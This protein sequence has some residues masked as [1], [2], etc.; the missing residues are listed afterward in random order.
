MPENTEVEA[1]EAKK[2][3]VVLREIENVDAI[4]AIPQDQRVETY[5]TDRK[6]LRKFKL[7]ALVPKTEDECQARYKCKLA[8]LIGKG[9]VQ[10]MYSISA[11][12]IKATLEGSTDEAVISNQ[13]QA[14]ADEKSAETTRK[15]GVATVVKQKASQFDILATKAA[16]QGIT[17]EEV[18]ARAVK[19]MKKGK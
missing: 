14:L 1:V 19:G 5:I 18:I 13:L 3:T 16:E 2:A 4:A 7:V 12:T 11:A 10:L 8:D 15:T 17:I 9:I 6:N